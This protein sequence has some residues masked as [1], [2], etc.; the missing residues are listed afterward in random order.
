MVLGQFDESLKYFEKN[1]KRLKEIGALDIDDMQRIGYVYWHKGYKEEADYYFTEQINYCMRV[2]ELERSY[3]QS[4]YSY[5]D[6]AGVY[7]FKGDK[8]KAFENLRI[9]NQKKRMQMVDVLLFKI[10]PLL[11]RIRDEPEFQQILSDVEAKYQAEHE[12][13]RQWLEENDML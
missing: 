13:V 3:S 10:D 5:F 9:F 4:Y 6:L 8:E 7:A 2:I 1:V 12:R 11:D